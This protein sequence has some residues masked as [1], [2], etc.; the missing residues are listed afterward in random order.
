MYF[1][2]QVDFPYTGPFG[3]EMTQA[4]TDLAHDIANEPG[5]VWKIWTENP[6]NTTSGGIY[7]FD[8]EQD[9]HRYLD[10]HTKRLV[11][12]GIENVRAAVFQ[13]NQPLSQITK[14]LL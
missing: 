1:I 13:T 3:T 12:F 6:D 9:V 14:A 5:L 4:F 10:K 8:N 2:L 7:L 11:S